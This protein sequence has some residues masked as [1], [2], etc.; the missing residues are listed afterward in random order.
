MTHPFPLHFPNSR[1]APIQQNQ[2]WSLESGLFDLL[3]PRES[4]LFSDFQ[5]TDGEAC[6]QVLHAFG[7]VRR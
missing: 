1:E 7:P 6:V 5:Q 3:R 2:D 4:G